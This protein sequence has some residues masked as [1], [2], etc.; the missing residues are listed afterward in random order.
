MEFQVIIVVAVAG[1]VDIRVR[2]I[3][4]LQVHKQ[5]QLVEL[6]SYKTSYI[7][8]HFIYFSNL[9]IRLL[10]LTYKTVNRF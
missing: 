1:G 5:N 6:K 3:W 10:H 7:L 4:S 9:L 2:A 8:S